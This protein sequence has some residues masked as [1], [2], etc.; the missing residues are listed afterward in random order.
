MTTKWVKDLR[1]SR[2]ELWAQAWR[3]VATSDSCR[4]PR[5]AAIWADKFLEE[6]DKRFPGAADDV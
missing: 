1:H 4:E 6:F 3:D 5:I 2:A